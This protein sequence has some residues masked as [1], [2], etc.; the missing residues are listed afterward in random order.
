MEKQRKITIL[1]I[2]LI[3]SIMLNLSLFYAM[4]SMVD[5]YQDSNIQEAEEWC[6]M[7]N[8][9]N[10]VVNILLSELRDYDEGYKSISEME[11]IE[12]NFS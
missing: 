5:F 1:P 3:I 6:E 8:E 9:V 2:A 7:I 4:G 11:M 12:C 10:E